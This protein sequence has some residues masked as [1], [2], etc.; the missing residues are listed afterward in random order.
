[1]QMRLSSIRGC[2]NTER[3]GMSDGPE[4]MQELLC[5]IA[6]L[7]GMNVDQFYGMEQPEPTLVCKCLERL[8]QIRTD[9]GMRR[10]LDCLDRIAREEQVDSAERL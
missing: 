8:Q 3:D 10:A 1:M 7:L 5:R 9:V 2:T 6:T 4:S